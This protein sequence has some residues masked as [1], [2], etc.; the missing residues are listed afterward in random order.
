MPGSAANP[1]NIMSRGVIPVAILTTDVFDA[2]S[3]DPSSVRFGPSGAEDT[4][5]LSH[6]EDVNSDGRPDLLLHF[7]IER[8][9]IAAG[10]AQACLTGQT[11]SGLK[12][13]GCDSI[14]T[15][16]SHR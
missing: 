8:S 10:D 13:T 9:G 12:I 15:V 5:N 11:T 6:I 7:A 14:S 2:T 1:I 16:P 3:V 4:H